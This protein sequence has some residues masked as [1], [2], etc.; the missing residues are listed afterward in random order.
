MKDGGHRHDKGD[1][2]GLHEHKMY[3]KKH[4]KK[5]LIND[6]KHTV[7]EIKQ[8]S[9]RVGNKIITNRVVKFITRNP[10]RT[11]KTRQRK[12]R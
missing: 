9:H 8:T 3:E 5:V 4:N 7:M 6:L 12:R 2:L 1:T 11:R 10:K